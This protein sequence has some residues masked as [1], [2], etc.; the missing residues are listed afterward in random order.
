LIVVKY[1]F[2]NCDGKYNLSLAEWDNKKKLNAV[3]VPEIQKDVERTRSEQATVAGARDEAAMRVGRVRSQRERGVRTLARRAGGK[4]LRL[5]MRFKEA[6]SHE[7]GRRHG[8]LLCS[9]GGVSWPA[10]S[11]SLELGDG[12]DDG[13]GRPREPARGCGVEGSS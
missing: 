11:R 7:D 2:D 13:F 12:G 3:C 1:N 5:V 4:R 6:V 8:G 9:F 10:P